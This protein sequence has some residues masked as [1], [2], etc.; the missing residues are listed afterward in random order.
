MK[1]ILL[2][3]GAFL[4]TL[5]GCASVETDHEEIS[6]VHGENVSLSWNSGTSTVPSTLEM[7]MPDHTNEVMMQEAHKDEL[8]G[9]F[10]ALNELEYHP[11]T[12]D[13]LPEYRLTSIG[14]TVYAINLSE[15]W[16]WRGNSE[17]AELSD[18]LATQLKESP[19]LVITDKILE[20]P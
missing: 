6:T 2:I 8:M 13:G 18:E 20:M 9:I 5:T 19:N 11:Y 16:V 4:F 10:D 14:G 15:K 12:C 17:Q 3:M 7:S 1:R